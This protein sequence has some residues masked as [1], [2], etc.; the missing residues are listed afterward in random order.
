MCGRAAE[1]MRLCVFPGAWSPGPVASPG[2]ASSIPVA[3]GKD[4]SSLGWLGWECLVLH[5][6]APGPGFQLD[7]QR[8]ELIAG[9][10]TTL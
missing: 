5:E 8:D 3:A 4:T 6:Q 7:S 2:P 1:P 9:H 10:L